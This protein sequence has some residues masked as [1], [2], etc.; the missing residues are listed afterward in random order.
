MVV[1][2]YKIKYSRQAVKDIKKLKAAR[3]DEKAQK[4]IEILR[5]NPF[6]ENP[7]YEALVG[8]L[9]GFYSRRIN[10][11]H[12]LVYKVNKKNHEVFIFRMW[13]H[14]EE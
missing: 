2:R 7:R 9:K 14:Y 3:L 11:H 5:Q 10:I 13:T 1:V 12:R 8:N 4:L 6:Q